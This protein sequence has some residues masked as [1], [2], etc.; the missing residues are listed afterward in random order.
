MGDL[1]QSF[2][3]TSLDLTDSGPLGFNTVDTITSYPATNTGTPTNQANPG[4]TKNFVQ[5]FTPTSTYSDLTVNRYSPL[6]HVGSQVLPIGGGVRVPYTIQDATNL[7]VGKPG[8]DGGIPY[9]QVKDPTVYPVTTQGRTPISG[10]F[11]EPGQGA[12]KFNQSYN[13]NNTYLDSMR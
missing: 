3:K 11:A 13:P 2:D 1:R 12:T 7:D 8:V 10:Y 9:K 4:P 5:K 6:M